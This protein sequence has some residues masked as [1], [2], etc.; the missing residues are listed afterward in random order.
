L[1]CFELTRTFNV[2]L[3]NPSEM[4]LYTTER[5]T[6]GLVERK[7]DDIA[8]PCVKVPDVME[9][10]RIVATLKAELKSQFEEYVKRCA[11]A[12]AQ[13]AAKEKLLRDRENQAKEARNK[14]KVADQKAERAAEKSAEYAAQ[15]ETFMEEASK[16]MD[17]AEEAEN[18]AEAAENAAGDA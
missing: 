7:A 18:A 9:M 11:E 5:T 16:K 14:Q 10:T 1:N 4:E 15:T 6:D 3:K 8:A 13:R 17:E 12:E 2:L